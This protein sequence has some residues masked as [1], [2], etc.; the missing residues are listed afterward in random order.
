MIQLRDDQI[1]RLDREA[2]ATGASRSK[3]LREAI[4]V[5]LAP[6]ANLDIASRYAHAYSPEPL[7]GPTWAELWWCAAPLGAPGPVLVL[8]RPEA[9]AHLPRLL[10]ARTSMTARGLPSEVA[11]DATDGVETCVVCLD[12]PES[13]ER[14]SLTRR[15]GA[16][17]A[18]R[19][20][21][22]AEALRGAVNV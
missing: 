9:A 21:Q 8:S 18:H 20:L 13:V 6:D 1:A 19:W 5:A 10:V 22:V 14:A 11:L 4:D 2:T 12:L 3:V 15:L 17:S 16:L 7:G